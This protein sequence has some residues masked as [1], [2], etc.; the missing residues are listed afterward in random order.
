MKTILAILACVYG[1]GFMFIEKRPDIAVLW[2]M[3]AV[4]IGIWNSID[5]Q[6]TP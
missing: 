2:F 4:L 3:V 5:R 6:R 1:L